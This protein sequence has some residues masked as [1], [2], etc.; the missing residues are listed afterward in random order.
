MSIKKKV[1]AEIHSEDYFGCTITV[2][3]LDTHHSRTFTWRYSITINGIKHEY[4]GISNNMKSKEE[5]LSRAHW[6]AKCLASAC[7]PAYD[8]P[9]HMMMSRAG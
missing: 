1:P 7:K 4:P 8:T 9:D 6:K 2:W 3:K 5:A